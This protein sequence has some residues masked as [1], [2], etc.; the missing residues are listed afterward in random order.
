MYFSK[1]SLTHS[2]DTF[3]YNC[4]NNYIDN[5]IGNHVELISQY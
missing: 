1:L 4:N 3:Y 2:S 5:T